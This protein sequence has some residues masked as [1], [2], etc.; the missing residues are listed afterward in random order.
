MPAPNREMVT[1][2]G[3]CGGAPSPATG[4]MSSAPEMKGLVSSVVMVLRLYS[5]PPVSR[6][7]K[8][9]AANAGYAIEHVPGYRSECSGR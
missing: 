3:T 8:E 1:G 6:T 4:A 7:T 5:R 9:F 2:S